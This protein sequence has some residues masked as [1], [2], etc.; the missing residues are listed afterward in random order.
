MPLFTNGNER[1][2]SALYHHY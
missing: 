1:L 2:I